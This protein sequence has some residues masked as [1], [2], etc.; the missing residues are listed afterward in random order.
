MHSEEDFPKA[1]KTMSTRSIRETFF[2]NKKAPSCS[3]N[4]KLKKAKK[5]TNFQL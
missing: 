4:Q 2:N 1:L 3:R 5:L